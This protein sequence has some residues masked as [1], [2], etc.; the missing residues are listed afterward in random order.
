[1]SGTYTVEVHKIGK[2]RMK[3]FQSSGLV[4]NNELNT[5]RQGSQ[6]REKNDSLINLD[7]CPQ[8]HR[9]PLDIASTRHA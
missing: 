6:C 1:M 8:L 2:T 7:D 3:H 5:C 9:L 4:D